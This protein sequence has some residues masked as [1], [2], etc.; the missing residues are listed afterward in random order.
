M[1]KG[2]E[3]GCPLPMAWR[4]TRGDGRDVVMADGGYYGVAFFFT[5]GIFF[6]AFR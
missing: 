1:A 5:T 3:K 2:R 4:T 6:N